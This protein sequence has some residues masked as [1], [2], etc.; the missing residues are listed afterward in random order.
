MSPFPL[1]ARIV[2]DILFWAVIAAAAYVA[3]DS[4]C[5]AILIATPLLGFFGL[6]SSKQHDKG[7]DWSDDRMGG[8]PGT[9]G[10]NSRASS[11]SISMIGQ[12]QEETSAR[13][14]TPTRWSR[15]G[16]SHESVSSATPGGTVVVIHYPPVR[17]GDEEDGFG[18]PSGSKDVQRSGVNTRRGGEV[19]LTRPF[20]RF[21]LE[22]GHDA[23]GLLDQ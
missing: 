3:I 20:P 6:A 8:H 18:L 5:G 7:I 15:S 12:L 13:T 16:V 1:W 19:A 2:C 23:S 11:R 22:A 14:R 4:L 10:L 9:P 21:A 17:G